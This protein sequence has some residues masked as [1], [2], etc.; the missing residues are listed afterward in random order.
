MTEPE[1]ID[2]IEDARAASMALGGPPAA[3]PCLACGGSIDLTDAET[4]G[5]PRRRTCRP[6]L[7]ARSEERRR[8]ELAATIPPRYDWAALGVHE[9][10]MRVKGGVPGA[11]RVEEILRAE[12]VVFVGKAGSGKTSLAVALLREAA[13][14]G[15][16]AMFVSAYRLATARARHR[17]GHGEPA[18]IEAALAAGVLLVDDVGNERNT[19][20]SDVRATIFERHDFERTI[21]VTTAMS[22]AELSTM[23]GGGFVRRL[24]ERAIV[25]QC[26]QVDAKR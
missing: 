23:Y 18:L 17:L 19:E 4:Y 3:G 15:A 14:R 13:R 22:S 6:C 5:T 16:E 8:R 1:K 9:L 10:G 24:T 2:W 20:L 21:W 11:D 26:S 25:V 12:R 7:R